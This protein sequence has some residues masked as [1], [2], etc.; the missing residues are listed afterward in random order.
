MAST[1]KRDRYF[2]APALQTVCVNI[3]LGSFGPSQ[4]LLRADQ[5]TSLTIAGLHGTALGLASILAGLANPHL[6]HRFGRAI[7]GWIGLTIFSIGLMAFVASPSVLFSIPAALF[8]GFGVSITINNALTAITTHF[9]E[10]SPIALTQSNAIGSCGYISGTLI[11]GSIANNYRDV[12][13]LGMLIAIPLALILFLVRDREP[14][15]HIPDEAGP[16][17]GKLS[18]QYWFSWV[19]FIACIASEF[20]ISFWAAAL[21]IDRTG[22]SPAIST[23]TVAAL[24][25]GMFLGR[26]YGGRILKHMPLD[27]QLK[28]II[29]IQAVGF[30]ILWFSHNLFLSFAGVLIAGVG[31]SNQ[32]ALASIRMI[33]FSEGRPDLAIGGSSTGAGLAIA[34]SPFLLGVLGDLFGISRAYLMVPV[35][36]FISYIIVK[37]VPSHVPQKVLE[38]NE[39]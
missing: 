8:T 25:T 7:T 5:G 29:A 2:W 3:F 32:F 18:R 37:L 4:P 34:G 27:A 21:I 24:G 16:Q 19:G 33:D 30:F 12:W 13:R 14:D 9:Q 28:L 31:V 38:D 35:L 39:L 23:L 11:V 22:A 1:F 17:S 20:A 15:L 26:W 6:A 36:I 10:L